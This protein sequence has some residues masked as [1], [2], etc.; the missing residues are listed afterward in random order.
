[1][2]ELRNVVVTFKKKNEI[3]KAVDNISLKIED[4]EI[5]GI[6]GESGAGKST[7]IRTLNGLQKVTSGEII[8]D[9]RDITKLDNKSLRNVRK[10]IGMIFQHFNLISRKTVSANI[11]FALKVQ[12]IPKSRREKRIEELLL[13]VGLED[14]KNVYPEQ[15]SG[16]QKQ[17]LGIAR[18]L[19]TN[20][21]ILLCDEATSALDSQTTKEIV[22]VLRTINKELGITIV[23]ITHQLEVAKE[24]FHRIAVINKG[25]IIEENTAYNIFANPE[26]I[27]T[28]TL[29]EREI[30]IPKSILNSVKGRVIT[31]L[32]KGD[33]SLEPVI[34]HVNKKFNVFLNILHGNIEYIQE[35]P[36]GT[37]AISID[38]DILEVERALNYLNN[39]V[40]SVYNFEDL[41]SVVV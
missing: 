7:L 40:G 9:G 17:R 11:D 29:V 16:G 18:A 8:I 5:Y 41:G 26:R 12:G 22:E 37:L 39:N 35:K 19:A 23:F 13:L 3:V 27:I 28:K 14:K 2:I 31:L 20:P 25:K 10:N 33:N 38:G 30:K 34:A 4:G 15:L 24:L 36:L 21:K 6:V 32:Y 1:M